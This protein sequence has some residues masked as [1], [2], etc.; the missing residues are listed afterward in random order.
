MWIARIGTTSLLSPPSLDGI[1]KPHLIQ[2][3]TFGVSSLVSPATQRT[4]EKN[5]VVFDATI[6]TE[7]SA[8]MD[9]VELICIRPTLMSRDC[10]PVIGHANYR[11]C[12][13]LLSRRAYPNPPTWVW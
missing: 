6:G 1:V 5:V 12:R 2:P 7:L 11:V 3:R 4:K 8:S 10:F 13:L 9:Q